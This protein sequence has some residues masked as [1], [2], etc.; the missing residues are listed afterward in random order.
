[1]PTSER[2]RMQVTIVVKPGKSKSNTMYSETNHMSFSWRGRHQQVTAAGARPFL[3]ET[4]PSFVVP[5]D[6]V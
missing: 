4:R 2:I 5:N 1:M 3:D 6:T